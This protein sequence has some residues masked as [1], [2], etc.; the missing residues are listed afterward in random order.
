MPS[1]VNVVSWSPPFDLLA[2]MINV[3]AERSP[4]KL[5]SD[6]SWLRGVRRELFILVN[7]KSLMNYWVLD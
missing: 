5:S 4:A 6:G 3:L 1:A 7:G 2:P